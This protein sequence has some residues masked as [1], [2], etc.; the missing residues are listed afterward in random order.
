MSNNDHTNIYNYFVCYNYYSF[1]FHISFDHL[2]S[3]HDLTLIFVFYV[4][5]RKLYKI[6]RSVSWNLLWLLLYP[7]LF[8]YFYSDWDE[9]YKVL[10]ESET[11][12]ICHYSWKACVVGSFTL[13]SLFY[14]PMVSLIVQ[15]QIYWGW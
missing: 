6:M 11:L 13:T 3:K 5:G 2:Y 9:V 10:N 1:F 15:P 4:S 8:S 7:L 12:L 14:M